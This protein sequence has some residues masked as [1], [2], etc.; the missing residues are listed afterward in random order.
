MAHTSPAPSRPAKPRAGIRRLSSLAAREWTPPAE[1]G[2]VLGSFG[3]AWTR[4]MLV[5]LSPRT[6]KS[7][8]SRN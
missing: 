7:S 3:E 1:R 4:D 8:P 2:G 5:W 6:R